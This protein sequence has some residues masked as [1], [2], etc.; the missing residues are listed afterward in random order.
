[1]VKPL[2][3]VT[4]TPKNPGVNF[5]KI[6]PKY[7]Q[8]WKKRMFDFRNSAKKALQIRIPVRTGRTRSSIQ[9]RTKL[10]NQ[11]MSG[12]IT[13]GSDSPV[14]KFL[15]KGTRPSPGRYLPLLGRRVTTGIHLGIR[16]LNI[17]SQ[18]KHDIDNLSKTVVKDLKRDF[19]K[20]IKDSF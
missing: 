20:S 19:K 17:I 8:K 5:K 7:R 2:I 12:T 16:A 10:N 15:D 1:M 9:A 11:N 3:R 13:V 18:A 14:L 6:L 4:F